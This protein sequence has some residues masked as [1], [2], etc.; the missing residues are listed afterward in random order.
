MSVSSSRKIAPKVA[1]EDL[2]NSLSV[3][4][5]SRFL[6]DLGKSLQRPE[7]GPALGVALIRLSQALRQHSGEELED[8]LASISSGDSLQEKLPEGLSMF[9]GGLDLQS[10][11]TSEVKQLL[12]SGQL[13]KQELVQVGSTR[14]GIPKRRLERQSKRTILDSLSSAL[15][16]EESYQVIGEQAK[17]EGLRRAKE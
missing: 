17:L 4:D 9:V 7:N 5:L 6:R 3:V 13:S 14:F 15:H 1:S 11:R 12:H 8:V 10:M 2:A 16:S